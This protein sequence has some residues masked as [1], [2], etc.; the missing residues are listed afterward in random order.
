MQHKFHGGIL[1]ATSDSNQIICFSGERAD[2]WQNQRRATQ[3]QQPLNLKLIHPKS[4][5]FTLVEWIDLFNG[6]DRVRIQIFP[7]AIVDAGIRHSDT[8]QQMN[9]VASRIIISLALG[10]QS[11]SFWQ[12]LFH[13]YSRQGSV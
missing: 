5:C 13:K 4:A 6:N 7:I 3:Q 2:W 12:V 11:F 8:P 9:S 10:C 1:G